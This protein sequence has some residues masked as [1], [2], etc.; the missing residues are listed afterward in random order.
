M[1]QLRWILRMTGLVIFMG[2][3]PLMANLRHS[4][5]SYEAEIQLELEQRW[6]DSVYAT[7]SIDQRIGQLFMIRAHSDKSPAYE[8]EVARLIRDYQVGGLCFF[9]GTPRRQAE[10]TN[11]YQSIS[12]LPLMIAMDAE[13]GLGMRL[14]GSEVID[15]PR[16]IALGAIQDNDLIYQMGREV[17]R[18]LRRIGVQVNFAPVADINNNPDNPVINFRSFGEDRFR[19]TE[20]SAAYMKGLQDGQVMACP[21]HFPGHGDT[22]V[23]SHKDLPVIR[24]SRQRLDSIELYPFRELTRLG[25]QSIMVAH[26]SIPALDDA[27]RMPTTLSRKV[28]SELLRE[29]IG[30][31][32]LIFT[33]AMEMRG[34]TKV[35]ANGEAELKA[36]LA[37]NDIILLPSNLPKAMASIRQALEEG[38]L[39][40]EE[41][42]QHVRR[43]LSAKF[44]LGLQ[45]RPYIN[46]NGLEED[47]SPPPASRLR[48]QLVESALTIVRN[49]GE[50]LPFKDLNHTRIAAINIGGGLNNPF[51][52]TLRQYAEIPVFHAPRDFSSQ[53]IQ[54]WVSQLRSADVVV[55]GLF[56]LS[57]HAR[58]GYGIHSGTLCF[59][60]ELSRHTRVVVV[61]F[62]NPYGLGK[63]DAFDWVVQS[64][65][66]DAL[67]QVR[68]AEGLMGHAIIRG[69]LPVTAS[70]RARS[71]TGLF[72]DNLFRLGYD[73]PQHVG[74]SPDTLARLDGIIDEMIRT[75][76]AP[77]GQVLV[78]KNRKVVYDRTFGRQTY[79]PESPPVESGT[80]YDLASV[81]KVAATTLAVMK[82]HEEG[83]ISI[84]QPLGLYLP[85]ARNTR[86]GQ[87]II[88]DLLN[89]SAGLEA[90][91]PLH[92][93]TL[94]HRKPSAQ[95][96][97]TASS[98]GFRTPVAEGLWLRDDYREQLMEVLLESGQKKSGPYVYS[99]IGF[100]LLKEMVEAVTERPFDEW[101]QEQF[102]GPLGLRTLGFNPLR[103]FPA[104]II[105]PSEEDDYFRHQRV[106]GYVHDMNAALLGG[107]SGHAGLFANAHDLAILFQ[108]LLNG[109]FYGGKR[110]F[111]PETIRLFTTRC[112]DC[113][114]RGLGFDMKDLSGSNGHLS[115][116]ASDRA[117]GHLGFTGTSVWADPEHDLIFIF[118]SNRTYPTMKV[119]KL[120]EGQF[121]QRIQSVVYQSIQPS[122]P[123]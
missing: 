110:Y 24:H 108:M 52:E 95:L 70:P 47:L 10:L 116:K 8:E 22:D 88:R 38:L 120:Q 40:E 109:G 31:Q 94:T 20:K 122:K 42:G 57:P 79:A 114:R 96:Y 23:D 75:Q 61:H 54:M 104:E 118:L 39:S 14:T 112:P 99:D 36:L 89:H 2:M 68:T 35:A 37:G 33:D 80:L 4:Y 71:G 7:L 43:I 48:S 97:R 11:H 5:R 67:T 119:N 55:A 66:E 1:I 85:S 77:G 27:L 103:R 18:Q 93:R 106:Q 26:L 72:G 86:K 34:V 59:L 60:E 29:Q 45:V 76:A 51:Q 46:L 19:V 102:Y 105:A 32:G 81:T 63:F 69:K 12:P 21:K 49:K 17:A 74:M 13:W 62:G 113:S 82:L 15:F 30:F 83:A 41:L 73:L 44:R 117:F 115:R 92:E 87:L 53:A 107:V 50:L 25:M 65:Q 90:W 91:I 98:P 123:L 16:Q 111:R 78:V 56:D 9:Q 100:I 101:M 121:R 58:N 64:N 84:F 3:L 28:V 6:V